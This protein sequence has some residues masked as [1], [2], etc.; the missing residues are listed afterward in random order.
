MFPKLPKQ[1]DGTPKTTPFHKGLDHEV[2]DKQRG[3]MNVFED[4]VCIVEIP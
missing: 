1:R 3:G 2:I 4:S